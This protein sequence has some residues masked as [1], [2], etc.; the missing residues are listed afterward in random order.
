MPEELRWQGCDVL[1]Q[2]RKGR[3]LQ[4]QVRFILLL[5]ILAVLMPLF[6]IM[7]I[8]LKIFL[9]ES[10]FFPHM[11]YVFTEFNYVASS[12]TLLDVV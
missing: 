11:R 10:L 12:Y 1:V 3:M 2:Y 6:A 4:C 5:K 7:N 8:Q 9:K